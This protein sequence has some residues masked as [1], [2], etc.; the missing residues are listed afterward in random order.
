VEELALADEEGAV[1]LRGGEDAVLVVEEAD[2]VDSQILALGTDAGPVV[3]GGAGAA[4]GEVVDGDVGALGNDP[5][6]KTA[7]R[8]LRRW[9]CASLDPAVRDSGEENGRAG[10]TALDRTEKHHHG[11]RDGNPEL[12]F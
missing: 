2:P 10:K 12:Y 4:E 1:A 6:S 9:A 11:W 5:A 3:F 7:K 8:R